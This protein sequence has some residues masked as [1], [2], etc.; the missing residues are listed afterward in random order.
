MRSTYTIL[1][2]TKTHLTYS[3]SPKTHDFDL[4]TDDFGTLK[5]EPNALEL[6]YGIHSESKNLQWVT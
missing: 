3:L 2:Y 6:G 5:A 1:I 4:K